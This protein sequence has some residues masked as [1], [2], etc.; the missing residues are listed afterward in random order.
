MKVRITSIL[1]LLLA[2]AV[3]NGNIF[4]QDVKNWTKDTAYTRTDTSEIKDT[5]ITDEPSETADP[6][7]H[8]DNDFRMDFDE[9]EW[10]FHAFHGQPTISL[11]YGIPKMGIDKLSGSFAKTGS[12]EI[13]LGYLTEHQKGKNEYI[14]KFKYN[15][16]TFSNTSTDLANVTDNKTDIKTKMWQFGFGT[17][18]GYGYRFSKAAILPYHSYGI[19]W[20]RLEVQSTVR[21]EADKNYLDYFDQSFRFGTMTEAGIRFM[22][23]TNLSLDVAYQREL[24]MPRLLFWKACGSALIEAAG[25]WGIDEFVDEVYKSSPVAAPIVNFVLKNALSY[26]VYELRKEKMNWPFETIA[27]LTYDTFRVGLSF[28]F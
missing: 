16:F 15:Y 28:V 6:F 13:R 20:S 26:G 3:I 1:Y 12:A 27:P 18:K 11:N 19:N 7:E 9:S 2:V 10:N 22:P 5:V 24:V 25:Q 17:E 23:I 4:A 14:N 21:N 8:E